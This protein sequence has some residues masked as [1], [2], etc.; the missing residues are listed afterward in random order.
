M[1]VEWIEASA[2]LV[3]TVQRMRSL[4]HPEL[5]ELN[6][7]V[8]FRSEPS[9][10]GG[11][12]VIAKVT[13]VTPLMKQFADFDFVIWVSKSNWDNLEAKQCEAL[14]DH[15]LCHIR[16]NEDEEATVVGHDFEEFRVIVER[17]GLWNLDLVKAGETIEKAELNKSLQMA[18]ELEAAEERIAGRTDKVPVSVEIESLVGA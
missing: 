16:M 3:D 7:G 1:A 14:I 12:T 11:K 18:M 9:M 5:V 2:T 13:K 4:Y 6:I 17:W 15:E 10:S 8:V